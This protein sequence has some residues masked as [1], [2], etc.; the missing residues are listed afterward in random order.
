MDTHTNA[1][2][3]GHRL[4]EPQ[5]LAILGER[6]ERTEDELLLFCEDLDQRLV[7]TDGDYVGCTILDAVPVDPEYPEVVLFGVDDEA[8]E[9]PYFVGILS[10]V[11]SSR[12]APKD[13]GEWRADE[14]PQPERLVAVLRKLGIEPEASYGPRSV[15]GYPCCLRS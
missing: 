5:L 2:F 7:A 10:E 1:T 15:A 13:C 6:A 14:W 8:G 3:C 9:F 11:Y 12:W 4:T